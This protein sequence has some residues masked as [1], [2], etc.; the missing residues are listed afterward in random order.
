MNGATC[1]NRR[2]GWSTAPIRKTTP[3]CSLAPLISVAGTTDARA[4]LVIREHEVGSEQTQSE[5]PVQVPIETAPSHEPNLGIAPEDFG[6]QAMLTHES[7]EK[8]GK[9][10]AAKGYLRPTGDVEE[11]AVVNSRSHSA[12]T[13]API[14]H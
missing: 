13:T 1:G 6:R 8:R 14:A 7:F 3:L 4:K 12:L 2:P 10:A 11:F 5:V 9:M